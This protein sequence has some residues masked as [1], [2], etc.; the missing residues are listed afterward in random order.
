MMIKELS[1]DDPND[2][3]KLQTNLV[4]KANYEEND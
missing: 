3:S 2:L 1:F 4:W